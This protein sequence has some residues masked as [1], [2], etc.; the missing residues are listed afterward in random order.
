MHIRKSNVL[1]FLP[2]IH[3][4]QQSKSDGIYVCFCKITTWLLQNSFGRKAFRVCNCPILPAD[5]ILVWESG[6]FS[7]PTIKKTLIYTTPTPAVQALSDQVNRFVFTEGVDRDMTGLIQEEAHWATEWRTRGSCRYFKHS[8]LMGT[9]TISL[10]TQNQ[11]GRLLEF[12]WVLQTMQL[13]S[14]FTDYERKL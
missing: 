9:I 11:E 12:E 10:L 1:F 5:N 3:N 2:F 4:S 7:L 8:Y 6:S 13:N 14:P